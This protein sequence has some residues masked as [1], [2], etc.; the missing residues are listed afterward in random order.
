MPDNSGYTA[1]HYAAC[2][3]HVD[4]CKM[5]IQVGANV[6]AQT[7]GLATPLH[8]AAAAGKCT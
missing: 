5:L 4:V 1:L 6:D 8:K 2:N 7:R 3:G